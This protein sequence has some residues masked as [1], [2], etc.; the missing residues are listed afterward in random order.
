MKKITTLALVL[1]SVV[2]FAQDKESNW[3][4]AG[5]FT[6]LFNQS[7]FNNDW[8][9]GGIN[10]IAVNANINYDINYKKEDIIWDTKFLL[11][12]GSTKNDAPDGFQ[13]TDDRLEI[14]TLW[15]KQA[16]ERWYYLAF[17]N[18]RTQF[19]EGLNKDGIAISDFFSPAYVQVGPGML[20]KKSDNFK[21]NIAPATG[22]FVF[23]DSK[24]TEDGPS[25]GVD[26]GDTVKTEVGTSL[27]I[28]YKTNVVKNVSIE[29]IF[30][31]FANYLA[32]DGK[33]DAVDFDYTLNIAMKINEYLSTNITAQAIY[34]KNAVAAIQ[35]REVFGVGFNYKF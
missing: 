24:F 15:G 25:F 35:V 8:Q 3:K 20:W 5:V 26:Q 14:N 31:A 22:R 2:S 34:D 30:N 11:A 9:G 6:L 33:H 16:T 28:Y 4:K 21:I 7:A 29:N 27:A 13:K 19:D 17:A 23:V 12:Y 1:C 10:N 32:D 18:L